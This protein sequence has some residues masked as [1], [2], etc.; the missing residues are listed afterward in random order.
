M[1]L[2]ILLIEAHS[3]CNCRCEMCDIWKSTETREFSLT[4]LEAQI[5]SIE[6]LG[7]RW[8]VFTGG[9]PLMHSDLFALCRPLRARGIQVSILSTGLL[10]ERFARQ[11]AED[12]DSAIVSMDGP[13][14]IHDAIRHIPGGLDR[15]ARG[16]AAIRAI[17]PHYPIAARTVVQRRNHG[18]LV[19]TAEAARSMG[20]DSISFLAADLASTAFNRNQPWTIVRQNEIAL[21]ASQ[22]PVLDRQL[23]MLSANAFVTDSQDHLSRI[24]AHFR[25][26]LGLAPHTSPKCNAPWVSGFLTTAGKLQPCFFHQE[27]GSLAEGSLQQV[28]TGPRATR[29]RD[30]LDVAANPTCQNCVCS[31]NLR[32]A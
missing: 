12:T 13:A 11:I 22:L 23:E 16:I 25:A 14:D 1:R 32:E 10:F 5:P 20:L 27:I 17:R 29:F 26:H 21:E 9:E 7:T 30:T 28:L 6:E 3:R 31:L 4:Q 8:V 15:I 24:A 18:A 19:D 2:P